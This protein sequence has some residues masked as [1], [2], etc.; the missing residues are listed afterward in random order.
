[1]AEVKRPQPLG[2]RSLSTGLIWFVF[3]IVA[4][5]VFAITALSVRIDNERQQENAAQQLETVLIVEEKTL[6]DWIDDKI[7]GVEVATRDPSLQAISNTLLFRA[8]MASGARE[9]AQEDFDVFASSLTFEEDNEFERVILVNLDGEVVAANEA[10]L[11]GEN[12]SSEPW[13][14]PTIRAASSAMDN[15]AAV[16]GPI[17]D[18]FD[19][20]ESIFFSAAVIDSLTGTPIGVLNAEVHAELLGEV[21]AGDF[22]SLGETGEIMLVDSGRQYLVPPSPELHGALAT[23]N[24]IPTALS[25]IPAKSA[26]WVD[27]DG[28]PVIGNY[29]Y[30]EDLDSALIVKRDRSEINET[31]NQKALFRVAGAVVISVV[32]LLAGWAVS[33]LFLRPFKRLSES[34]ESI[35]SGNFSARVNPAGVKEVDAL[36]RPLN[37]IAQRLESEIRSQETT[38]QE[39][40]QQLQIT[41]EMGRIIAAETDLDTL[42]NLTVNLIRDRLKYYH[43]QVFLIDDLRQYAVLRASTGEAGLALLERRHKLAVGSQSVIGRVSESFE[44]VLARDT[45]TS[46]VHRRNEL[47]P[48]TRAELAVPLRIRDQIIGALDVQSRE[49]DAFDL[50][51][52]SVLQTVADQ[53]AVAIRNAQLFQEKEGLLSASL[54]LTQM[55]TKDSWGAFVADR[56]QANAVGF[57]YDLSDVQV[58]DEDNGNGAHDKQLT[59][60][61][62]LRG[63]VI[64]QLTT[65][66]EPGQISDEDQQLVRQVLD[67]VALAL[68]NA[69]LFEQTQSSLSET[70]RIYNASQTITG[71]DSIEDLANSVLSGAMLNSVDR[72]ALYVLASP[73]DEENEER[74]PVVLASYQA[75]EAVETDYR[76][77]EY[78]LTGEFPLVRVEEAGA[79]SIVI[80]DP[81][82]P[83]LTP[84]LRDGMIES[85]AQSM[86]IFPLAAGRRVQAWLVVQNLRYRDAFDEADVRFLTTLADQAATSLDSLRLF[87]QTQTRARRLQATNQ[88]TRAA[89]S[90]LSLDILL[91]LIVEQISQAFDYYHVQIFLVDELGEWANLEASTGDVGQLLLERAHRLAVGSQS[92]IGQA[93]ISGEP[94]IVRDVLTDPTHRPNELLP[95]TR[96]EMAIPLKTGDRIIG[97]L[98]V[99]S[100]QPNAF[101][102]EARSILQS[103]ADQ[104]SVTLENAQ[105]FREIQERVTTLTT[106]NL[107]STA[108]SRADTKDDLFDVITDQLFRRTFNAQHGFMG[109]VN[110][111]GLLELPILINNGQRL[112]TPDPRPIS[113]LSSYVIENQTFLFLNEDTANRVVDLGIDVQGELPKS[114]LMVPLMLGEEAIGVISIQDVEKENAY[115]YSDRNQLVT[116]APYIAVKIRNAELLEEAES[117]ASELDFLFRLTQAAVSADE[118]DEAL[119]DVTEILQ[120]EFRGAEVAEIFLYNQQ[121]DTLSLQASYGIH[122]GQDGGDPLMTG[123]GLPQMVASTRMSMIVGDVQSEFGMGEEVGGT[124]AAALV[125]L[126][127]GGQ[128]VGVVALESSRPNQFDEADKLLLET[129]SNTLTAIIQNARLIEEITEANERLVELDVLKSQF[130]ANMSHELRTP[131]NSIIGF[132]KVL[133]KGIDGD[134]NDIQRQD[135]MTI[136]ESGTHL[137]GLINDILDMSKIESGKMEI[138]PEYIDMEPIIEGVMATG[139]GLIKDQPLQIIK[140]VS[141]DLPKV[142]GDQ[143]RIRQV[144][145]NLVSNAAKFTPE[146]NIYVRAFRVNANPEL[147]LPVGVQ[148]EVEDGGIGIPEEHMDKLFE[149]F[150]QVDGTT[151]RQAGGT[152]LGLPISKEFVEMHGGK[153]WVESAIDKGSKFAFVIPLH[154]V[155]AE[156]GEAAEV[157]VRSQGMDSDV[158][159]ILAVDD[160]QGVLD[161]YRRYLEKAGYALVGLSN[162]NDIEDYIRDL[163]PTAIVLDL[164]LPG[165]DGWQ[166]IGELTANK[167]MKHIPILVCSIEDERERGLEMGAAGYL[168]KPIIEDE[169]L[170]ALIE[171]TS[172]SARE[173]RHIVILDPDKE[174]AEAISKV[175]Q[176]TASY[177]TRVVG[178]GFEALSATQEQHIDALVM[179][180]DLKDMDGYGLIMALRSH[181]DTNHIPIVVLTGRELTDDELT[182]LDEQHA[183]FMDKRKYQDA[184]LLEGLAMVFREE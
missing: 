85:D 111:D 72:A 118:L 181:P 123:K 161:L 148:V 25:G 80:Q 117:R 81:D 4:I 130:L 145:L 38:I 112:P 174:Y 154:P 43:A 143:T 8:A 182:R 183:L 9:A 179:N 13:F 14:L 93:T 126:I 105:L 91:P 168:T 5:P 78:I 129:A 150:R 45:D 15:S 90:V 102:E 10:E 173:S 62:A 49:A 6:G 28:Q 24:I 138:H 171:V 77:D 134:L 146:G 175:L 7:D 34:V 48:E 42:L 86:G 52:I 83:G 33:L 12:V 23:G 70:N 135:L 3:A 167:D 75:R 96:A 152:G 46:P 153:M 163:N 63:E 166:V 151:T 26:D 108:V 136:N 47:L 114:I 50:D 147:G 76:F 84:D 106:I 57:Q 39:R 41:T 97:A 56:A 124:R 107:V 16:V 17:T 73:E 103:L 164:N 131:L 132:S 36:V 110:R 66:I 116:L 158:P 87:Q 19:G 113:G 121:F 120:T 58:I 55:L 53:L 68:D 79:N 177:S 140:E 67:R 99:Q 142:Y 101:D 18:P 51:T 104:I 127:T 1:M 21:I 64:G 29:R 82:S 122:H 31:S 180:I 22:A 95:D 160:E 176:Q 139:K 11:I 170:D 60:P 89:S 27:Y 125:P 54:Q 35:S 157:L 44:Y 30:I 172:A 32:A 71:A 94:V 162:A 37:S 165:K 184:D 141:P 88:V 74:R 159:I 178:M 92:V 65:N 40:T 109:L 20:E 149:A 100:K 115:K 61:I 137:L 156:E 69:R 133:I 169:L 59:L 119:Q 98:D 155:A 2:V 128:L 144:L